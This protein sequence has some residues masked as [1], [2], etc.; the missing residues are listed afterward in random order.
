MKIEQP[1]VLEIKKVIK[2]SSDT[3]TFLFDY[4]LRA[5]PGQFVSVWLPG[6]DE[7]PFSVSYQDE[8]RFGISCFGVG[9]FSKKLNSLRAGEKVGIRGPYGKGFTS[10]RGHVA[11]VGGG[12]GAAPLAFLANSLR[13]MGSKVDF[14][15]GAKDIDHVLF[16]QRL[17]KAG[18]HVHIATDDGSCGKKGFATDILKNLLK[19]KK[20]IKMVYTCGPEIMM[21]KIIDLCDMNKKN[22]EIS[23]E[24]YMKCGFGI[25]GQCCVDN[26]GLR[27][28][29]EGPV[30]EKNL[31]KRF[32]EFNKYKRDASGKKIILNPGC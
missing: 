4:P 31:V 32:F 24:R 23:M 9:P 22:C 26:V 1:I 21:K 27:V 14:I 19:S 17:K 28:C 15:I 30:F 12:C 13:K 3:N 18:V 29:K 10:K 5:R 6:V 2:E 20:E 7:K 25:C 11:L 16:V 8:K